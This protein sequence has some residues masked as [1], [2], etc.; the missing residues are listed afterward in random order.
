MLFRSSK[1]LFKSLN[2]IDSVFNLETFGKLI[3]DYQRSVKGKTTDAINSYTY[4]NSEPL[5]VFNK[6]YLAYVND[7]PDIALISPFTYNFANSVSGIT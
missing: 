1:N 2:N 5:F 3:V 4:I 7:I 6:N